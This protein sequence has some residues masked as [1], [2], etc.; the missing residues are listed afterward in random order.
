MSELHSIPEIIA[1]DSR[2]SLIRIPGE[3]DVPITPRI[4]QLIDSRPF[5]RL[6]SI[7][8]LGLVS[9]VYPGATHTRFE[10][11][12]GVYRMSL[13]FLKRLATNPRFLAKIT[14]HHAELLIVSALLHD[15]GHWPYCHP[16]ED[17]Q[18]DEVP[19]HESLA[20]QRLQHS[21]V[22]DILQ[23]HFTFDLDDVSQLLAGDTTDPA[24]Q[25]LSSVLSGPADVDKMDY[26]YRDSLH[27]GVPYGMHYD[28]GR[29]I[30]SLCLDPSSTSLA[31]T[32]KGVTAAELMVFARYVMF[33]EVY[34]H[35]AVRSATAMLQRS[36]YL[37]RTQ[38]DFEKVFAA[39]EIEFQQ[40]MRQAS[41]GTAAE[42]LIES[43]FGEQRCLFKRLA[44]FTILENRDL[45]ERV[46]RRKYGWLVKCAGNFSQ[47]L[48]AATGLPLS[49]ED[50]LIDAPPVGLEV[51]FQIPVRDRFGNYRM[52]GDVSPVVHTLATE[53]FDNYVKRVRIFVHP[54]W[55]S[56]NSSSL[57][58]RDLLDQAIRLT[59]SD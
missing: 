6:N 27:A 24:T 54:K 46:S 28:R 7:S 15:V 31:I 10:H 14:P 52:I 29:L 43:L 36:V 4:R 55:S 23:Q 33:S 3:Q 57:D 1:L 35:H 51:Q 39:T 49:A 45:F 40:I 2:E 44:Q 26:L 8:Q 41:A 22:P 37:L 16:I 19:D 21:T 32:E 34:W 9:L 53:Q 48:K 20:I 5:Q 12:L 17:M 38:L 56:L 58:L 18:L 11:S 42:N 13:M 50:I 25:L 59:E 30:G 47:V